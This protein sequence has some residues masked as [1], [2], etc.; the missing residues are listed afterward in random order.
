MKSPIKNAFTTAGRFYIRRPLIL[1]LIVISTV[2]GSIC[3][4]IIPL[5]LSQTYDFLASS[6]L[7]SDSFKQSDELYYIFIAILA[8]GLWFLFSSSRFYLISRL[9]E[10]FISKIRKKLYSEWLM[11]GGRSIDGDKHKITSVLFND[12]YQLQSS[13]SRAFTLFATNF[14]QFIGSLLLMASISKELIL[15][16]LLSLVCI[17]SIFIFSERKLGVLSANVQEAYSALTNL[18]LE[19][20]KEVD[21]VCQFRQQK[22]EIKI[23]NTKQE[24]ALKAMRE[25]RKFH[26]LIGSIIVLTLCIA[27]AI[28]VNISLLLISKGD[29]TTSGCIA[30]IGYSFVMAF[31]FSSLVDSAVSLSIADGP[32]KRIQK[33]F[34][35]E[36]ARNNSSIKK[37]ELTG[38][39][40]ISIT[41][42]NVWFRYPDNRVEVED[43][44]CGVTFSCR[45]NQVVAIVGASG[46]GKSTLIKLLTGKCHPTKG[47]VKINDKNILELSEEYILSNICLVSFN[48]AVF[49]RTVKENIL[50]ATPNSE[51]EYLKMISE[52]TK[53][54]S[55]VK[56]LE[57]G[58]E[59]MLYNQGENI[60]TGQRQRIAIARSLTLNFPILIF[61]EASSAIDSATEREIIDNIK[62]Y[63]PPKIMIIVSH[64]LSTIKSADKILVL[65]KGRLVEIGNHKE[66]VSKKGTYYSIF[67]DQIEHNI[68]YDMSEAYM[69]NNQ[70]EMT[71]Y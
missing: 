67:R 56:S 15:L 47:I 55:F 30:F 39:P 27:L 24:L 64:R 51:K 41:F 68:D 18:A 54:K 62:K 57:N 66:L 71:K 60:S 3:L 46:S 16:V 37:M 45:Q 42:D 1:F 69:K 31:S 59:S 2:I 26:V 5:S 34:D 50:Y 29:L 4:L 61:D 7:S 28:I 32:L 10:E 12:T 52:I 13:L 65:D 19:V 21:V 25:R 6:N 36:K 23:F 33:F 58:Y 53:T 14:P 49:S 40:A 20:I 63:M 8:A 38:Q 17:G 11:Q 48:P 35:E 9:N 70:E 22:S 44:I 43:T